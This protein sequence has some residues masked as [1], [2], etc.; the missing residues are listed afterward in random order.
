MILSRPIRRTQY[1][2][3]RYVGFLLCFLLFLAASVL[4][5]TLLG[6]IVARLA[7]SPM[8]GTRPATDFLR[9]CAS[10]FFRAALLGAIVLFFSTFLRGWG[11]VL[12]VAVFAIL[13]GSLISLGQAL[14]LTFLRRAG[15]LAR[16][17]LWPSVPWDAIFRGE[18]LLSESIGRYVFALLLYW[19]LAVVIFSARE[20]SYGQD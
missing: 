16:D 11:D 9:V 17:N 1:L 12:A 3:G 8:P 10:A 5:A 15:E 4:L 13:F 6:Q 14:N 19:T 2:A 7:P 18:R 20:F